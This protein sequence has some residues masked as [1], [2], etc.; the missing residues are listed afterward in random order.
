MFDMEEKVMNRVTRQMD[1]R[2]Y[3]IIVMTLCLTIAVAVTYGSFI[4]IAKSNTE[5]KPIYKYYTSIQIQS[6]D[7]LWD[8]ANDYVTS[9]YHSINE[10]INE[11]KKLNS[12]ETDD[13]H[14]GQYLTVPYYSSKTL[15]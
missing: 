8:L 12:L 9:E 11:V 10:Y 2:R 6:G 13:I 15:H 4:S 7:T 1:R 3:D 14:A 5:S